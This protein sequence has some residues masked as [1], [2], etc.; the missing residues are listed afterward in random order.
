LINLIGT[1]ECKADVKGRLMLPVALKKQLGVNLNESFIL[2]RS[3]FQP[4]LELHPVF[5]WKLTM[6][7]VN[8]LNRFVKKNNDFIRRY[9][10]G[11]RIVELDNSGRILIPK[12]LLKSYFSKNELVLASAIN[13]IEIW[14]KKSYEEVIND[15][16]LDFG[17]LSE[18]VMGNSNIDVS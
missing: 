11:V 2:K 14:D 5:E 9:T 3:V 6:D 17:K 16:K 15:P 13:I 4:C 8:M 12:D 1:Y 18:S 7:K 10:A